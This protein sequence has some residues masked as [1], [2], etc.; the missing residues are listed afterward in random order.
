MVF[1]QL[2]IFC[3]HELFQFLADQNSDVKVEKK[4]KM[5]LI[6]FRLMKNPVFLL[7]CISYMIGN[8]GFLVPYVYLIDVAILSVITIL[9]HFVISSQKWCNNETDWQG[10]EYETASFLVSII[11]IASTIGRVLFG[12]ISDLLSVD[13]LTIIYVSVAICGVAVFCVPFCFSYIG[14]AVIAAI[15]GL[16]TGNHKMY[17][18]R[19]ISLN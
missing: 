7:I 13:P 17:Y 9:K 11:G 12:F 8:F 19:Y 1:N 15:F 14:F 5:P 2:I 6:N 3:F 18:S 4:V 16:L 10:V